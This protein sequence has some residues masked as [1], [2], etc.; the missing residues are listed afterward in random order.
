[1]DDFL[2]FLFELTKVLVFFSFLVFVLI[3]LVYF[4]VPLFFY[5]VE[6]LNDLRANVLEPFN[7]WW[8]NAISCF[9]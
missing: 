5:I 4:G 7:D 8:L 2:S 6:N 1:M 9:E 3:C